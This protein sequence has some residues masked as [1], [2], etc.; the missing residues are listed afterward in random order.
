[1]ASLD[2]NTREEEKSRSRFA[3]Y[4]RNF[5]FGVEDSLVSTVGL[6]SG[7]AIAGVPQRTII[8]TGIVLVFV[9]A[10]SMAVGSFLS[11]HSAE[12]YMRQAE[13]PAGR[14]L[15]GGITMFFSY[16]LS[17][18]IPLAPYIF[19]AASSTAFWVSIF[20]SIAALFV[21][22]AIGGKISNISFIKSGLRMGLIG[23]FAII[24]GIIVGSL[25]SGF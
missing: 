21:L 6:L 13:S 15:F 3:F 17:G 18:F 16:F 10:F 25:M 4:F 11:E 14:S 23:G 5:V 2:F 12:D 24:L 9:E 1:M 20:L 19:I 22:G 8:L 7:V